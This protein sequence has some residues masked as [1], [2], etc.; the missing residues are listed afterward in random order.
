[1]DAS[2]DKRGKRLAFVRH[3]HI[4]DILGGINGSLLNSRFHRY[5]SNGGD[6]STGCQP[7]NNSK[8]QKRDQQ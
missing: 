3:Y 5:L 2:I 1:V 4:Y 6:D 7:R 8:E